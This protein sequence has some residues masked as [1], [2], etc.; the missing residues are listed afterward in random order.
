MM[1]LVERLTGIRFRNARHFEHASLSL[2]LFTLVTVSV[3]V[4]RELAPMGVLWLILGYFHAGTTM[5]AREHVR[6]GTKPELFSRDCI[7]FNAVMAA[8]HFGM[9]A[10]L[11]WSVFL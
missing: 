9:F 4:A 10:V 8:A 11:V 1:H 3:S 2:A 6:L 5:S 7:W